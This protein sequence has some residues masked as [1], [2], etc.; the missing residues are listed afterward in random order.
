MLVKLK[1][2]RSFSVTSCNLSFLEIKSITKM[3]HHIHFLPISKV[4]TFNFKH[5]CVVLLYESAEREPG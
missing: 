4:R 3:A 1:S 5:S 2:V